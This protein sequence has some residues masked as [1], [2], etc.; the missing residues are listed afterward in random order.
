MR[1]HPSPPAAATG[2]NKQSSRSHAIF[3]ITLEQR[4]L[5]GPRPGGSGRA[6]GAG[7][8]GGD[9]S[10]VEEDEEEGG[11]TE[12]VDDS[13]LCAKMHLV[14]LA[15]GQGVAGQGVLRAADVLRPCLGL[16][17][18]LAAELTHP[19]NS[20]S[21]RLRACQAHQGGGPAAAGGHQHQQGTRWL[22]CV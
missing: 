1:P 6:S 7:S 5:V 10:S 19:L 11:G 3:T 9:D 15:G 4:R 21:C 2:M 22:H 12:E 16:A 20:T 8:P 18:R 17:G 14:D 13:Y